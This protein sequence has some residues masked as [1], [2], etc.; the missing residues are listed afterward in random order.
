MQMGQKSRKGE[1][2]ELQEKYIWRSLKKSA[3]E[4]IFPW[5]ED[6]QGSEGDT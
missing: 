4:A 2:D 6:V 5:E 1:L 3:R